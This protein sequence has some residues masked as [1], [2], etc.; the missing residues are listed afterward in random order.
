M[1]N[2]VKKKVGKKYFVVSSFDLQ[3]G[4]D[5]A[6]A[7]EELAISKEIASILMQGKLHKK[8]SIKIIEK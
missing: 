1:T 4:N 2:K 7:G 6:K 3:I 8:G 5:I